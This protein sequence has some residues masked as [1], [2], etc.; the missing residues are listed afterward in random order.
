MA[1]NWKWP[2]WIWL[3]DATLRAV[4]AAALGAANV[5]G[6][7]K[8]ILLASVP[9][10]AVLGAATISA[11]ASFLNSVGTT[12]VGPGKHNGTA[13]P[14]RRVVADRGTHDA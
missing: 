13:S 3:Q 2:G 7:G 10:W 11:L 1:I 6:V 9:W 14:L 8:Y 4:G 5:L 12:L